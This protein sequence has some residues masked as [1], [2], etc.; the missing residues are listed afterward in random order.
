MNI[1]RIVLNKSKNLYEFGEIINE[2]IR[3]G[4]E[5]QKI[6]RNVIPHKKDNTEKNLR[7]NEY[8]KIVRMKKHRRNEC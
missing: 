7:L 6:H 5:L 8:I 3:I 1:Q 4:D 2:H